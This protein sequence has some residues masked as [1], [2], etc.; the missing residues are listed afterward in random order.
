[1][2]TIRHT[3]VLSSCLVLALIGTGC[4]S[5]SSN[6]PESA[7]P[8]PA[9]Q[10]ETKKIPAGR[11]VWL[12]IQGGQRRVLVNA[13]VCLRQGQL[14]LLLCKKFTKEH[15]A[16]LTADIDARD[17]HKALLLAGAEPGTPVQYQPQLRP[18][19]GTRIKITLQY[20]QKGKRV[21]VPAQRW[22][23]VLNTQKE[24]AHDWVFAGSQLIPDPEDKNKPPLYLANGGDVICVA[25]FEDALLD[26]PINSSKDNDALA[27]EAHTE[28]IPPLDTKVLVILEPVLDTKKK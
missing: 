23:R 22:V 11:N 5:D 3:W 18:P 6:R 7:R 2:R 16:V 8:E 19:T 24:L 20:E 9:K 26:L 25:N 27:F 13:T 4:E 28:Q 14:E 12:E 17:I 15:E 10:G 21:T 1:M